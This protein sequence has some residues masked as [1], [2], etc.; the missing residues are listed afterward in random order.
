LLTEEERWALVEHM[1]SIPDKP[2]Q[3]T[4]FGGPEDPVRAWKDKTFFNLRNPGTY[5]GAPE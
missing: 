3:I 2:A 1:K 4:P 5:N